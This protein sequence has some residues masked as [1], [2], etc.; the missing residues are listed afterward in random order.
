MSGREKRASRNRAGLR[1][2]C[3]IAIG[4]FCHFPLG[5]S[6]VCA[7]FDFSRWIIG[8]S[9]PLTVRGVITCDLSCYCSAQRMPPTPSGE[10]VWVQD[11]LCQANLHK[12][13][14]VHSGPIKAEWTHFLCLGYQVG[15][16]WQ[17]RDCEPRTVGRT[18]NGWSDPLQT[19]LMNESVSTQGR[20]L[21]SSCRSQSTFLLMAWMDSQNMLIE[22]AERVSGYVGWQD[23]DLE[24]SQ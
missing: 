10:A 23:L 5:F 7:Y 16:L 22:F 15:G 6:F 3:Q 18:C 14:G 12:A 20:P 17:G 24:R 8:S 9:W 21:G 1:A 2:L 13:M 11:S 4:E 19:P